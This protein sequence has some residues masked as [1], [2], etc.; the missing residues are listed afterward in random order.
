MDYKVIL[1]AAWPVK[2]VKTVDD[3]MSVAVAE[4]GKKL[5]PK[6]SYVDIEV[7]TTTC[8]ACEETLK[9][10]FMAANTAL[11]GLKLEMKVFNAENEE[12][13]SRITKSVI[14]KV[15]K[16]VP[17]KVVEIIGIKKRE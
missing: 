4:A 9:S 2:D 6:L 8:P 1:E 17:L 11:V 16:N 14:G 5:N 7:G 13:A 3:A 12:H 15:L 10:V